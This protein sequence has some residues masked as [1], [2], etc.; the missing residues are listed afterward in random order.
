[1]DSAEFNLAGDLTIASKNA[2]MFREALKMVLFRQWS[3][4]LSTI[5]YLDKVKLTKNWV[6][7]S[8]RQMENFNL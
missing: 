3:V 6:P 2:V 5:E 7:R 1:M 4:K 8:S